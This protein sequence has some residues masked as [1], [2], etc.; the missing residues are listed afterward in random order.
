VFEYEAYITELKICFL[1]LPPPNE[2]IETE[3][4]A[5]RIKSDR[6]SAASWDRHKLNLQKVVQDN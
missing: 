3:Q 6:P 2:A 4:R 1:P 5:V